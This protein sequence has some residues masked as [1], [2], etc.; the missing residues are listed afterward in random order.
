MDGQKFDALARIVGATRS[1]R[2]VLGT[3]GGGALAAFGLRGASAQIETLDCRG[4]RQTCD[5]ADECCGGGRT[6]CDR[7][8]RN[9]DRRSL[10][11]EDRCCGKR[12][13]ACLDSCDC[14]RGLVCDSN[15][16]VRD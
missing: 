9:C 12:D 10:R 2:G 3:L 11:G 6:G 7:I 4:E 15:R 8:S 13:A 1:R 16:C 14:C 5:N